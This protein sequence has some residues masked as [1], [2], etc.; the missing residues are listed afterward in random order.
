MKALFGLLGILLCIVGYV[1]MVTGTISGIGYALYSWAHDVPLALALWNGFA[2]FL[3]MLFGG[4]L[5]VIVGY[6]LTEV[7][8]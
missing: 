8:N 6:I 7:C 1:C 5:S 3:K 4:L 2:L